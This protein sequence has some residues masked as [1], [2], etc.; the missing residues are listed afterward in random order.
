MLHL[1]LHSL[2]YS[3]KECE[4]LLAGLVLLKQLFK[5]RDRTQS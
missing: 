5:K 1:P 3:P 2:Q 4:S